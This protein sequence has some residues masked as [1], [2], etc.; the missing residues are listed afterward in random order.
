MDL[1]TSKT[2]ETDRERERMMQRREENAFKL[3]KDE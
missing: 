1:V 2:R 3:Y